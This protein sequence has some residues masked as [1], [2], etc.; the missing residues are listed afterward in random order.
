MI[1][2]NDSKFMNLAINL[3]K[4]NI[5]ITGK[6][7]SVGCVIVK[8]NI[9]ISTGI[10]QK[11]GQPHAERNAIDKIDDKSVIQDSTFYITLEPCIK[12]DNNFNC[13]DLIISHKP[14]KVFI[15]MI[16]PNPEISYKSVKKLQNNNIKVVVNFMHD[17][18]LELNKFFY[19][20]HNQRR[21]FITIKMAI[22][23]DG[24]IATSSYDSK[25]ITNNKA[26]DYSHYLR[27]INDAILIGSNTLKYDNP[28]LDCRISGLVEY[29]PRIII[30]T[31]SQEINNSK[32]AN[33]NDTIIIS[34]NI[35]NSKY[36]VIKEDKNLMKNLFKLGIKSLIVEGGGKISTFF[37]KN[38]YVDQLILIRGN[39]II[40]N[41]GICSF[42]KLNNIK[43]DDIKQNFQLKKSKII[44][45]NLIDIYIK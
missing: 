38:D 41:D 17:R 2:N 33:R 11:N 26:R 31:N 35:N 27:S 29:S 3:A 25:W 39:K 37:L 34:N 30:M 1:Y 40:G 5:G 16:D 14:K 32:I 44:S 21:P 6:N 12:D 28:S 8:N 20:Y 43:I 22:S 23:L 7:P 36:L 18:A 13:C 45:G 10:T 19:Y 4:R 15:A 42:D 9:I 24:K